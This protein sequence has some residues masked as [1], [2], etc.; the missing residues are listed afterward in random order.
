MQ[1][2]KAKIGD[3]PRIAEMAVDFN[4]YLDGIDRYYPLSKDLKKLFL[5]YFRKNIYSSG[6]LLLVATD[7][8]KIIGHALAKI[9]KTP[10]AWDKRPYG[11]ISFIYLEEKYQRMGIADA[12]LSRIYKWFKEKKIK[13]V[14]L[15]VLKKNTQARKAWKKYGFQDYYLRLRKKI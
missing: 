2:R 13:E 3:V 15:T 7:D 9:L 6:S 11:D 12:F 5:D 1:I 8:E 10:L 14:E 4:R